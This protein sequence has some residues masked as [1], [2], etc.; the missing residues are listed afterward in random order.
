M[1]LASIK[2]QVDNILKRLEDDNV[3]EVVL[4]GRSGIG[5]TWIAKK[6]SGYA[7]KRGSFSFAFWIF[8]DGGYD[9]KV[10]FR[11]IAR[12]LYLL[13]D[14]ED[15]VEDD[16][17]DGD[18]VEEDVN[19]KKLQ[20]KISET[21]SGKK[22]FLIILDNAGS[23]KTKQV[24]LDLSPILN[25]NY[26]ILI[27]TTNDDYDKVTTRH[28]IKVEPLS[29]DDSLSLLE[30]KTG[31]TVNELPCNTLLNE[32]DTPLCGGFPA[33][34]IAI[35]KAFMYF[36]QSE[37]G[38]KLLESILQEEYHT[39][40]YG[41]THLVHRGYDS[42]PRGV[43]I[44]CCWRGRHFF[45]NQ[46]TVHCNELIAYWIMEGYLGH[47]DGFKKAYEEGHRV[48]ME[49]IDLQILKAMGPDCVRIEQAGAM[50][51]LDDFYSS[52][53]GE[54]ASLGLTNVVDE[55]W[56]GL[57]GVLVADG[58]IRSPCSRSEVQNCRTV[59]L[60]G[61][62]HSLEM[63]NLSSQELEV[64]VV[65]NPT[66]QSLPWP[67]SKM[68]KLYVLLF[69]GCHFLET[70]NNIP[71][72]EKLSV[73][74]ISG[75]SALKEVP[76]KLFNN[77][78]LLRSL[79]LSKLEINSLP[80]SFYDLRELRWVILRG[81]SNLKRLES[82][83]R[84][85]NLFVLDL[86][87]C[88]S[89]ESVVDKSFVQNKELQVLNL[90]KTKI[91]NLPLLGSL[92][93]LTHLLLSGCEALDRLRGINSLSSLKILNISDSAQFK[94]FHDQSLEDIP[95]LNTFDV[96]GTVVEKLPSNIG[97]PCHLHLRGCKRLIN[98]QCIQTLKGLETLVLSEAPFETLPHFCHLTNLCLL[99]VSFC[100]N[101]VK[102][103]DLH[104]LSKL[105]VLDLSGCTALE[106]MQDKSFEQMSHLQTLDL[107]G[108]KITCLPSL[109]NLGNLRRLML[110]KCSQLREVPPL[111]SL[112]KL[113]ELNLCG[114]GSLTG[115]DFL[116]HMNHLRILD[117]SDT[118]LNQLPCISNLKNLYELHLRGCSSLKEVPGLVALT[119]LEV[120][121][122]SGTA[123]SFLPYLVNFTN[124]HQL[125]L[126]DCSGLEEFR[127]LKVIDLLDANVKELPY[128]ISKLTHL[129]R[130][131]LPATKNIQ[132]TNV[133]TEPQ[134]E[135][136]QLDWGISCL[137]TE[138]AGD[139]KRA[140]V[141]F[142][143]TQFL[144]L[145]EQN[146]LLWNTRFKKFH[147]SICPIENQTRSDPWF[148]G[149][150]FQFRNIHFQARDMYDFRQQSSVEI[151]GFQHSPRGIDKVLSHAG[152]IFL[153]AN[154]FKRWITDLGASNLKAIEGCWIE[155]CT[156]MESI[157][158]IKES[159]EIAKLG[160][161]LKVLS[162]SNAVNLKNLCSEK[163]LLVAVIQ[164]LERL[165]L[166]C[167]PKLS[168]VFPSSNVLKNLKV[169]HIKFCDTL[170]TLFWESSNEPVLQN[171]ETLHLWELPKIRILG[172]PLPSLKFLKVWQ[173]PRLQKL[174]ETLASA[175]SLQDLWIS[176]VNELKSLQSGD[177]HEGSFKNL[178][179]LTLESCP[180]LLKVFSSSLP[181]R[182]LTTIKIRNCDKLETV[183]EQGM[184]AGN[185]LENLTTLHLQGL[186]RLESVGRKIKSG[187]SH[188]IKN[189]PNCKDSLV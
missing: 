31:K 108:T 170:E 135:V 148:C 28:V 130:L 154:T 45:R 134:Q 136:T 43:L 62:C 179:C 116:K 161:N 48:L 33:S 101:L 164:S 150:N 38:V 172:S 126:K 122:L 118:S 75:P 12:Q 103:P 107:S 71:A 141:L 60:D 142:S 105:E 73:L 30:E 176:N 4:F 129:E 81:C 76:D 115:A 112:S 18:K 181:M 58:I 34:I 151:C 114:I 7:T 184:V 57:G 10:L 167:C 77:I 125:L 59:M 119:K 53:F 132:G 40:T 113:E 51:N 1:V 90:S 95:S 84:F 98:L 83:K 29:K 23:E 165:Y 152:C 22:N 162:V 54:T 187:G 91:K 67:S 160:N 149:D 66:F 153:I 128:G 78:P 147:F 155:R 156:G 20:T 109:S 19:E 137:A 17:K 72:Y 85:Q 144:Q 94:E 86:S 145:L 166:D 159:E 69:R 9:S 35:S 47:V 185:T 131:E 140:P 171:L 68:E 55:E 97:N 111:E 25:L 36:G 104:S 27:T 146:Q 93:K 124:L 50:L 175:T 183:F 26:K 163:K 37:S 39:E 117:L 157:F 120:L 178:K 14:P 102:F 121:D 5:K 41:I 21:L 3:K 32:N 24:L 6:L 80:P 65:F 2:Q 169:L 52:G 82:L 15:R 143:D 16:Y 110:K 88:T 127:N 177:L 74:E 123:V 188:I 174:E 96:S 44:D 63:Q 106:V 173:C 46:R 8:P 64:I 138:V 61:N 87:G 56:E 186:P 99:S 49:L 182:N 100:Q 70:I 139:T 158:H 13:P 79:N 180:K 189:C 89:L 133:K 168:T 42:L 92:V 11:N